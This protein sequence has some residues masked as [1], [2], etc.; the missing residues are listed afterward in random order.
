MQLHQWCEMLIQ[1]LVGHNIANLVNNNK[2]LPQK[3]SFFKQQQS[4]IFPQWL[5]FPIPECL[6]CPTLRK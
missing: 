6:L 2:T 3:Q 4:P 5:L 1:G